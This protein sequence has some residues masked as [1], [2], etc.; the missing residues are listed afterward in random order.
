MVCFPWPKS[1]QVAQVRDFLAGAV[2]P[3]NV[4]DHAGC[5]SR[6]GPR[7]IEANPGD[8]KPWSAKNRMRRASK[9]LVLERWDDDP[10][11][12][13]V[14][15]G[16]LLFESTNMQWV[17]EETHADSMAEYQFTSRKWV[18]LSWVVEISLN[19]TRHWKSIKKKLFHQHS[20]HLR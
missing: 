13:I 8:F 5:P 17:D 10:H 15:Y 6:R 11:I 14:G 9:T 18:R 1:S 20:G 19:P 2:H 16:R 3:C 12:Q 4:G 7:G